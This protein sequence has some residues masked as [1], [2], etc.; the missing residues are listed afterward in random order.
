MS[1]NAIFRSPMSMANDRASEQSRSINR[2]EASDGEQGVQ[3]RTTLPDVSGS[4][5]PDRNQVLDSF[6]G[7]EESATASTAKEGADAQS[8]ASIADSMQKLAG[9]LAEFNRSLAVVPDLI[10]A[11]HRFCDSLED[12][13]RALI[14]TNQR[15]GI[16]AH[17]DALALPAYDDVQ[18]L[19]RGR[20]SG[21]ARSADPQTRTSSLASTRS[22]E[23]D[24][25][26]GSPSPAPSHEGDIEG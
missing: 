10:A 26:P 2:A 8:L 21:P 1:D 6:L 4:E 14:F 24:G 25:P 20:S 11:A 7:A 3:T 15:T 17:T 5:T 13:Q 22:A 16:N 9:T 18:A 23:A 12:A 19:S